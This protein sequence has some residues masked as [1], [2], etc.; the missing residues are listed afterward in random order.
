MPPETPI[1]QASGV[2]KRYPGG[3]V[4]LDG[5]DLEVRRGETV[6]LIGESGSGKTTLL[7]LFNRMTEPTAGTVRVDGENVAAVDAIALRRRLGY[8]QQEGGLIPHWSVHR[9]VQLVP[10]LSGWEPRRRQRRGDEMLELVGLD[11]S[12][13]GNRYPSE[14]SG[15]QRQRVALARALAA[16][17]EVILLDE[18]F[19]ALDALTRAELQSQFLELEEQIH[20]TLLLVTH[21]LEEAFLLADRVGVMQG[22]RLLQVATPREL[23]AAPADPYVQR[24]LALRRPQGEE[25]RPRGEGS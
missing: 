5:V 21:D 10:W 2:T 14:L 6:A 25:R 16:E 24:L 23:A 22:G 3:V 1:L 9:N 17:P 13:H 20:K 15:G 18:P 12:T 11:P 7:R 4:A 19:G 8:V